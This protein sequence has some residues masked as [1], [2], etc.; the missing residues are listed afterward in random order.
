MFCNFDISKFSTLN[1]EQLVNMSKLAE[2]AERYE[3][4]C[5]LMRARVRNFKA[6]P[7]EAEERNL[8]SVAYKNVVSARR[9][10]LRML[11]M[12]DGI[13]NLSSSQIETY[14]KQVQKELVSI[15]EDVL[16][17][18]KNDL[19]EDN[20]QPGDKKKAEEQVFYLKLAADYYRYLNESVTSTGQ[21][22]EFKANTEKYYLKAQ[23]VAGELDSMS[24]IR[25]GLALNFSVCYYEI[26]DQREKACAM[27]KTAFDDAI[28]Q[29][30]QLP[31]EDY[32]DSTLIM[33]LL[34]DNLT[35]WTQNDNA[36][37]VAV[38]DLE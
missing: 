37:D 24:P 30:D 29:L 15:S 27:A 31:E 6:Q 23:E 18:L 25:L 1:A 8:L 28:S 22:D 9:N 26:L 33:Q 2:Q 11:P 35:L 14:Q 4:M 38:E 36:E 20:Y 5:V 13:E 34:R 21:G 32:K 12:E 7:L 17:L 19:I 10:A 16:D 3:D